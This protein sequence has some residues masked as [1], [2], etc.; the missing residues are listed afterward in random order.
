MILNSLE[1]L[2]ENPA[3]LF[4][5]GSVFA[6]KEHREDIEE[7]IR[8]YLEN[9]GRTSGEYME[10]RLEKRLKSL[11]GEDIIDTPRRMMYNCNR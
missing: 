7:E 3:T 1:L 8:A 11:P 2:T 6:I 4:V 9:I 10:N 5:G